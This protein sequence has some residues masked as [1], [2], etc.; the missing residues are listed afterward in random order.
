M[1]SKLQKFELL[2]TTV[3]Q[4]TAG[5]KQ[6]NLAVIPA[7]LSAIRLFIFGKFS[8]KEIV[9]YTLYAPEVRRSMPVL[10]S[11]ESSLSKLARINPR[12]QQNQTENKSD[13]YEKCREANLPVPANLGIFHDGCGWDGNGNRV[14]G[15]S[16][17]VSYFESNFPEHFIVKDVEGVYASGFA[18]FERIG[19]RFQKINGDSYDAAGLFDQLR[20]HSKSS[21]VLQ[22]RLFNHPDFQAL[23]S[24]QGLHTLRVN[25]LRKST[26]DVSLVYYMLKVPVGGNITDNFAMGTTGNLL[27]FGEPEQGVLKGARALHPSGSGLTTIKCHPETGIPFEGYRIPFWKEA[28]ELAKEAHGVF[29]S[30]GT[31]GWDIALTPDGPRL[32]E[33]NAWWDPPTYAPQIMSPGHWQYIFG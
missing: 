19:D 22:E 10:I 4:I 30:F 7:F 23:S 20:R 17:W 18:A 11:K 26:G 27:A 21:L 16:D 1:A 28:I 15:K 12:D 31:L 32:L 5:C 6:Q 9:G 2:K 24:N 3:R 33:A 29:H 25:T 13:F 14:E 8:L